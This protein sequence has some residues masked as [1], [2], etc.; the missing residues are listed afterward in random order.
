M[1]ERVDGLMERTAPLGVSPSS[2]IGEGVAAAEFVLEGLCSVDKITRS[3]ERGYSAV[4]RKSP[5]DL[6]R[7][8]SVDPN[9]FK[10]PLN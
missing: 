4:E 9:R 8:Y 1:F 6:Y 10:K 7:N 3:E 2:S 5:Q